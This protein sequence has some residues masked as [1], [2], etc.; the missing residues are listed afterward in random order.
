MSDGSSPQA[1]LQRE[2]PVNL[3]FGRSL[4]TTLKPGR[5]ELLSDSAM[6]IASLIAG[7]TGLG[8]SLPLCFVCCHRR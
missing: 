5:P 6:S 8:A 4:S 1:H 3:G 2:L 7:V